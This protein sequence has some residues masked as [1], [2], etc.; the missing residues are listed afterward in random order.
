[1][2]SCAP[3]GT[4]VLSFTQHSKIFFGFLTQMSPVRHHPLILMV[5]THSTIVFFVSPSSCSSEESHTYSVCP[6]SSSLCLS[7]GVFILVASPALFSHQVSLFL[8][9]VGKKVGAAIAGSPCILSTCQIRLIVWGIC[10]VGV[11][12]WAVSSFGHRV[13]SW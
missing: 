3:D 7:R 6:E 1:M 2:A 4:F 8:E 9:V 10:L 11:K 5:V 12:V 13:A